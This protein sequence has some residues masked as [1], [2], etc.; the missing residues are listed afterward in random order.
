M[1]R[2]YYLAPSGTAGGAAL[3]VGL[4]Y[5]LSHPASFA[6]V[7][8]LFSLSEVDWMINDAA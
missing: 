6:L 8:H 7:K 2:A 3:V 5:C 4:Q 1:V